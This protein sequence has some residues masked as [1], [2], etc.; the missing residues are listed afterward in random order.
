MRRSLSWF[1]KLRRRGDPI[2]IKLLRSVAFYATL[3]EFDKHTVDQYWGKVC[4]HCGVGRLHRAYYPRHPIRHPLDA[5]K[6]FGWNMR[7]SLCCSH[8]GC[9]TRMMPPS[10][11]FF[12]RRYYVAPM[13]VFVTAMTHGLTGKRLARLR[14]EMG[15]D[16][17]TLERWR[18]WW[19]E[20]FPAMPFW[21]VLRGRLAESL[22][23]KPRPAARGTSPDR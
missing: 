10:V 13:V 21:K 22:D 6:I 14:E 8:E 18:V 1:T 19:R 4:P 23:Q 3:H 5:E 7:Y 11:R 9:R 16:R 17:R 12:A 2:L 20:S 15:L